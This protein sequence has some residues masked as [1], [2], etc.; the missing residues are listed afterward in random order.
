MYVLSLS[1]SFVQESLVDYSSW[2]EAS[3]KELQL[4]IP[5]FSDPLRH[6]NQLHS[7]VIDDP[8]EEPPILPGEEEFSEVEPANLDMNPVIGDTQMHV[9]SCPHAELLSFWRRPKVADLEYES[10]YASFGPS[11]KYVTFEPGILHLCTTI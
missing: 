8:H 2:L 7:V 10:P 9:L 5:D 4:L 3:R 11:D 6:E 1:L